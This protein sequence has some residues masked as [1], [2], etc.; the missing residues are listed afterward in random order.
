MLTSKWIP[1]FVSIGVGLLLKFGSPLIWLAG[2]TPSFRDWICLGPYLLGNFVYIGGCFLWA[3]TKQRS[4]TW[5]L[6]GLM[7]VLALPVLYRLEEHG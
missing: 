6:T 1:T 5:G 2:M 4:A 3:R 7:C